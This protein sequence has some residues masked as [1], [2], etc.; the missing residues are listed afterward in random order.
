V[1]LRV[2]IASRVAGL[3]VAG[4]IALSP[5]TGTSATAQGT[6]TGLIEGRI[7][8]DS[9]RGIAGVTIVSARA[10]GSFERRAVSDDNGNFRI[11]FLPPGSYDLTARRIGYRPTTVTRI[12]VGATRASE[13]RIPMQHAPTE[14]TPVVVDASAATI[15]TTTTEFGSALP[16]SAIELLPTSHDA[17]D[18]VGFTPGAR[19]G[20]VW[21]GSTTQANN[22]QLDGVAVNHP[23]IGG[24]FLQPSIGWI[25]EVEVKGLG[26]GAEYGNFQGG[27]VNVVTRSG[28]NTLTGA[29]RVNAESHRFNATNV[30]PVEIG[31]EQAGRRELSG[32]VGG[33]IV[34]DRLFYFAGAQVVRGETRVLDQ[35][36]ATP[37]TFMGALEEREETKLLGKLTW[38]PSVRDMV[39]ASLGYTGASVERMGLWGYD[40]PE[41][42]R[43]LRAPV[44]FHNLAWQRAL[45]DQSFLEVKIAG[46][47]GSETRSGYAGDDVPG[48]QT[49]E[50][51]P[52][53]RLQNAPVTSSSAP[54][55]NGFSVAWDVHRQGWF[56][57]HHLKVGGEHVV[58]SWRDRRTRT[59]GMT[60]RPYTQAWNED[61]SAGDPSTWLAAA[62]AVGGEVDLTADVSNSAV[63][64]QDYISLTRFMTISPG[65]RFGR[66]S[67]W[68]TPGG[69]EG[70]RFM[71]VTDSRIEPRFG[72]VVD[73]T[74][75]GVA[76]AKA[77]WGRYHQGMFSLFF[78][79]AEG[80]NV[81]TNETLW[82]YRGDLP[83]D[84]RQGIAP[85]PTDSLGVV[86]DFETI[87]VKR[88]NESGRVGD[89]RQP[90]VDQAVYGLEAA[91]G[92]RWKTEAVF[93]RRRNGNIVALVDENMESNH[94]RFE[95]V[96]VMDTRGEPVMNQFGEPLVLPAVY[97]SND[98]IIQNL[99]ERL[100]EGTGPGVPGFTA[101]DLE[102]LRYEP[103]HVLRHV[104]EARRDFRQL[105]FTVTGVYP[106]FSISA[107]VAATKLTGN[108]Y[109][110]TGYDDPSGFGAGAF[111]HP[112]EALNFHGHLPD[113]SDLE[114]KLRISG[115]LPW[116]MRGG[117]FITRISGDHF[118][119]TFTPRPF[120]YDY[121]IE[122]GPDLDW[123]LFRTL[124]GQRIM[125]ESRGM[126]EYGS[127]GS[128]DVRLERSFPVA[129]AELVAAF[130]VFNAF[131]SRTIT[132][133]NTAV[134][135]EVLWDENSWYGGVRQRMPPR[136]LRLTTSA[137]F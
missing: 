64:V 79:R 49:I 45:T 111:V 85:P 28:S 127:R 9:A 81:F 136:T 115:N 78:D 50:F 37:G 132:E 97:I 121:A 74:G 88:L 100:R 61:F 41:A 39:N 21:G 83:A 57:K 70:G 90:Y 52:T 112:N 80:G 10:D 38:Q 107:T 110:V 101:A 40:S 96:R 31:S 48:V 42:A 46:Y 54:A 1:G 53:Q 67:G 77:H 105:Q 129:R 71:A 18:L 63:Y 7:V 134:D 116:R 119:P 135:G 14:L 99:Q 122:N 8:D 25:A 4:A 47:S 137:R 86:G 76:V 35:R 87:S 30:I 84:A 34:R 26:A 103:D 123:R 33:P 3:M 56:M 72:V 125:L 95:N 27:L 69:G 98:M 16:A 24:D 29:M 104:P 59:A 68:L 60:W 5:V 19:P 102:W 62:V 2:V 43:R 120:I 94:T 91:L 131:N 12:E 118:T 51:G 128:V 106:S 133:V 23:G 55:S 89:Y 32:E 15:N 113:Y 36:S 114:A 13:L 58:G 73:P 11:G 82:R 66:W 22:Y 44:R 124:D 65:L 109:S 6:Q 93:V 117:L 92:S 75:R 108:V 130:D 20:Q 17:R 126:R